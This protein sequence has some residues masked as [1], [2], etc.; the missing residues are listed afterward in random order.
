MLG[1]Y[2][3]DGPAGTRTGLIWPLLTFWRRDPGGEMNV[4]TPLYMSS[5][6]KI[7]HAMT[8]FALLFYR[9]VDPA[10]S[11]TTV[12][13]FFIHFHD[14]ATDASATVTLL[15]GHRSGPRDDTTVVTL[16][17][18]RRYKPSGWSAGLCRAQATSARVRRLTTIS[19][20]R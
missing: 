8:R 11:T 17:F 12:F 18:W 7:E 1:G 4:I 20:S 19:P 5:Y 16:F 10:G 14:A 3:K 9:R 6:D 13:P 15:G 2:S